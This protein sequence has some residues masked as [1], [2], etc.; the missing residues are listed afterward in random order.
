MGFPKLLLSIGLTLVTT[1]AFCIANSDII[2]HLPNVIIP[3]HYNIRL[4]PQLQEGIFYGET[5]IDIINF[6]NG[7]LNISLHSQNLVINKTATELISYND[8]IHKPISHTHDNVT[9]ILTLNFDEVLLRGRY[10]LN[11]KFAGNFSETGFLKNGFMK[12]PYRDNGED[13]T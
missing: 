13:N 3:F 7:W 5:E 8:T 9:N 10:I 12:I 1:T 4:M 6:Y 11:M 2:Y